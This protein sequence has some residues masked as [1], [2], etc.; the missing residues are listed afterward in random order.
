MYNDKHRIVRKEQLW[1]ILV[2]SNFGKTQK[3]NLLNEPHNKNLPESQFLP[4]YVM[5]ADEVYPLKTYLK[6]P[7]PGSVVN[8]DLEKLAVFGI[9]FNYRLHPS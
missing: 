2:D 7:N 5:I 9:F 1:Q 6:R 3:K 4:P 8:K